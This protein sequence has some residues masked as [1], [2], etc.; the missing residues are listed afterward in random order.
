MRF[1]RNQVMG[2]ARGS[3]SYS[4]G[5]QQENNDDHFRVKKRRSRM[6]TSAYVCVCF[7]SDHPPLL[8]PSPAH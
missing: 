6:L 8:L 5:V 4:M 3:C 2:H 7:M 1:S